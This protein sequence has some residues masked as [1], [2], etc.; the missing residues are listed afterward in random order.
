MNRDH[1]AVAEYS[2]Q[3]MTCSSCTK[4]IQS[5]VSD[6]Q[7]VRNVTVSLEKEN[8]LVAFDDHLTTA[9]KI[10]ETIEDCGFGACLLST[11]RETVTT[12]LTG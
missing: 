10:R 2:V 1:T 7:G 4:S 8:C 12:N 5:T 9:E 11:S 3:G 6:E